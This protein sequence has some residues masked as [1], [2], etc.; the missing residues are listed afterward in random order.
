MAHLRLTSVSTDGRRLLLSDED[1]AEHVL[2]ITADLRAAL[3]AGT[4]STPQES[5]M[6]ST[7]RP[8]DIQSRIRSGETPESVAEAAGTTVERIMPFAGPVLAEREHVAERAQLSHVRR[9][10][11]EGARTLGDA[12]AAQLRSHR[13]DPSGVSWDAWRKDDGRWALTAEF[14]SAERSGTAHFSYDARGSFVVLDDDD[15][16]WLVGETLPPAA[17]PA[18]TEDDLSTR[19]RRRLAAL[20]VEGEAGEAA[21]PLGDDALDLLAEETRSAEVPVPAAQPTAETTSTVPDAPA[22]AEPAAAPA[23][24]SGT[25]TDEVGQTGQTGQTDEDDD[26]PATPAT[27]RPVQKRRGRASVPSWDEIMF[28]GSDR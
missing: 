1:G 7:L 12:V 9:S 3:R 4:R 17:A 13:T 6:D 28:G 26:A 27:R 25:A 23:A 5:S 20:P 22:A 24:R 21:L 15:A 10:G 8:R 19:R 16:R 2:E 11:G 18:P 14:A